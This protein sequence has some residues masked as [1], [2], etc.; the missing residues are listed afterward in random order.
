MVIYTSNEND[1]TTT[2][3]FV[4]ADVNTTTAMFVNEKYNELAKRIAEFIENELSAAD[5]EKYL[6]EKR[7]GSTEITDENQKIYEII[8]LI[9]L[10]KKIE[11]NNE[12]I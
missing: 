2:A 3:L 9:G 1:N 6:K 12:S 10:M 7:N 11:E 5:I 8:E 4:D